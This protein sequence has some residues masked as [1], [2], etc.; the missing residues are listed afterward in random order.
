MRLVGYWKINYFV[1]CVVCYFRIY[2]GVCVCVCMC[3]CVCVYIY[4]H[5]YIHTYIP[6]RGSVTVRW[7]S[8]ELTPY[9]PVGS[10]R[11]FGRTWRLS[12]YVGSGL[13]NEKQRFSL[14]VEPFIRLH[15]VITHKSQ[16]TKPF[17]WTVYI[18]Y[19]FTWLWLTHST[20]Q[21]PSSKLKK[22]SAVCGTRR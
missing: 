20:E 17:A 21:T 1:F 13:E 8:N 10:Y 4:T 22:V 15:S 16:T 5:I 11:R 19:N 9:R 2:T 18:S 12:R 7:V 3:V 6:T 14:R